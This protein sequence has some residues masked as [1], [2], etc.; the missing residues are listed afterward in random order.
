MDPLRATLKAVA[1]LLVVGATLL[2]VHGAQ[3]LGILLLVLAVACGRRGGTHVSRSLQGAYDFALI[4]VL[5]LFALWGLG[6][7][8]WWY[9][10]TYR[11]MN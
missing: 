11:G 7:G 6:I 4:A 3:L 10:T 2:L 1:V 5:V 9:L 8:V